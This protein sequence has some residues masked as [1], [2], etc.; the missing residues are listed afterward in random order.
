MN[1]GRLTFL[2][3]FSG[4]GGFSLGFERAGYCCVGVVELDE[5]A[6][7]T[8]RYNF[9][10]HHRAVLAR[11]G[12]EDGDI[13]RLDP[14]EALSL[15]VDA[16]VKELDVL[17]GGPPCQGLSRVGRGKLDSLA[18]RKG[19]FKDD[20]RNNL[21]VKVVDFLRVLR[22]RAFLIENVVGMLHLGDLNV[23][24]AICVGAQKEGYRV[25]CTILNA[26]WYGVPQTRERVFI[27]GYRN[28]LAIDPSFPAPMYSTELTGGHLTNVNLSENLFKNRSFYMK[29]QNP[30]DCPRAVSVEEA[31]ADLPQFN[32][33]LTNGNYRAVRQ[34]V[35]PKPYKCPPP[36]DFCKLM[37]RWNTR[38]MLGM[39]TDHFCRSTPRDFRIFA[40]MRPGD[41]YPRA[42][43]VAKE[44]YRRDLAQ[45]R[46]G[47]LPLRPRRKDYV[48]PYSDHSFP[49][50]WRKLIPDKP[51]WTVTAHLQKDC[52]SHIHFDD[53][54]ARTITVREAARLQ[55]FP[56]AFQFA[57]NMGDCYR[58]I[59]NAVPPL[60]AWVLAK[61]MAQTLTA[62][63]EPLEKPVI[64]RH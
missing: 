26:A 29:T 54:Q 3:L 50:K 36:N 63:K 56:D 55:S 62:A 57:G 59:G 47:R 17:L 15:L 18:R 12:P 38:F 28:D 53:R 45:Y 64:G 52:Y 11:L 30:I 58:Q 39:V 5:K 41:K 7:R 20:H 34:E 60:L 25:I 6:E 51:S 27:L 19:A 2:D 16:G 33:H 14:K 22:P 32:E 48:P 10:D 37:R 49:D 4:A 43:E 13:H 42:L 44:I 24:E 61:H 9:P 23:A 21:Y 40:K 31:F 46:D 1:D 8:Y 35:E